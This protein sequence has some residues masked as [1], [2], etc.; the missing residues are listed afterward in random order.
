MINKNILNMPEY[1]FLK[2]NQNLDK[3]ICIL[4][5]GGSRA[6]GTNLPE[7][8]IDIRGVA[9]RRKED[10]LL[11]ND[12]ENFVDV[13]TD[14]TIYSFDKII[15]LLTKCNPNTIE[16]L[17]LDTDDYIYKNEFGE[18]LLK[19]KDI[20][21]SNRCINTFSEYALQQLYRMQQK[22][23]AA[24]TEEELNRHISG[25]LNNMSKKMKD[26]YNLDENNLSFYLVDGKIKCNIIATQCSIEDLSGMLSEFNNT[27]RDYRKTSKRNEH[28]LNHGK[29]AKHSM[30]LLRLY[31][32]GIDLVSEGKIQTKRI[33]EHDLLMDIRNGVYLDENGIP[34]KHFFEIVDE[35]KNKFENA[36]KNSVLPDEPDI[37]KINT[38]RMEVNEKIVKL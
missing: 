20:F 18:L 1:S 8:D 4:G 24:L 21:L 36:C 25:V 3:N 34:N 31:M 9:I 30:H 23:N 5:L 11:G 37:D 38:F 28:A 27:L 7:S 17:G 13:N 35:Y 33:K 2:E 6:Y 22:T 15:D 14:T 19:N 26:K 16:L 29:I 12:F 32:M 10:I